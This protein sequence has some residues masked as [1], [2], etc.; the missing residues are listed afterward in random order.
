VITKTGK[1]VQKILLISAPG[2]KQ[3][4]EGKNKSGTTIYITKNN[5]NTISLSY[6]NTLNNSGIS[7]GKG[8]SQESDDYYSLEDMITSG[9]SNAGTVNEIV[10]EGKDQ[11][12]N[13]QT[14]I[15]LTLRNTTSTPITITEIGY[16]AQVYAVKNNDGSE[17]P[18]LHSV[19]IDRTL[20]NQPITIQ[21]NETGTIQY[22]LKLV[23]SV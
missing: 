16:T 21:P 8:T 6:A 10:Q 22:V 2:K 11:N 1:N 17:S 5:F 13:L 14:M 3:G 18:T 4:I 7:V 19:L 23:D 15:I 9:L 20:L 12:N